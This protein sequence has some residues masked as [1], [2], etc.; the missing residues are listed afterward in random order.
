MGIPR[1]ADGRWGWIGPR[2]AVCMLVGVGTWL[3]PGVAGADI[4]FFHTG[5][6]LSVQGH[7]VDG[8][9]LTLLLR[10][11]GEVVCDVA[12]VARIEPDEVPYP[13][14]APALVDAGP[15]ERPVAALASV[16]GRPYASLIRS[17]ADAH[18][19]DER[20]V[21]AVIQVESSYQPR[22]RSPKGARGLMQLMPATAADYQV[23]A[24]DLYDPAANLE[25]GVR[26]LKGLLGR[27]DL[28][29]ALA[30]YNAGEGAVRRYGGIPPYPETRNYVRRVMGLLGVN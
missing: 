7:R 11:G 3:A 8:D 2:L 15:A 24:R 22:A 12:L 21:H 26:H 5:R 27:F 20:L 4:V 10:G 13:V 29:L 17:V 14:E 19:V 16:V 28:A 30:A 6:T 9:R 18:G 1:G 23:P 25:A